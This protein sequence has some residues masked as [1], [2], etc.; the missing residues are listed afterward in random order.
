[1]KTIEIGIREAKGSKVATALSELYPIPTDVKGVPLFT[2]DQ[3]IDECVKQWL[4]GQVMRYEQFL[5]QQAA[6]DA[7]SADL[8][9]F[10]TITTEAKD[11]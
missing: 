6:M 10:E 11:G 8:E 5:A 7:V 3:W 9:I 2:P 1:M 4:T